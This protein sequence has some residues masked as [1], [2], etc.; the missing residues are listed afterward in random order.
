MSR[1]SVLAMQFASPGARIGLSCLVD[2]GAKP[3]KL[4]FPSVFF[5]CCNKEITKSFASHQKNTK[6]RQTILFRPFSINKTWVLFG[7]MTDLVVEIL[8]P[9]SEV[10]QKIIECGDYRELEDCMPAAW[11]LIE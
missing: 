6:E 2:Q 4:S 11:H 1:F 8:S 3:S 5:G 9:L 10:P 7:E